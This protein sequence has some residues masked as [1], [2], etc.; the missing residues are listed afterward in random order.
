MD[1]DGIGSFALFAAIGLIGAAFLLGPIGRSI[2]KRV[3]GREPPALDEEALVRLREVELRLTEVEAANTRLAELE[4]RLD[5]AER[6][7]THS[8]GAE[9]LP[10]PGEG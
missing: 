9:R 1:W 8:S 7:L 10:G 4:E 3:A 2:A 6:L 5:F